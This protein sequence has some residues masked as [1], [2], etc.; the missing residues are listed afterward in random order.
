MGF[1][2]STGFKLASLGTQL[3]RTIKVELKEKEV[4]EKVTSQKN[5]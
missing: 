2:A 4:L 1:V 3:L 5:P